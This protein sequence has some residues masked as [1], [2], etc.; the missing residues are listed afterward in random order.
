[1]C[2]IECAWCFE[3]SFSDK[4]RGKRKEIVC[5]FELSLIIMR[6]L[7]GYLSSLTSTTLHVQFAFPVKWWSIKTHSHGINVLSSDSFYKSIHFNFITKWLKLILTIFFIVHLTKCIKMLKYSCTR[8]LHS[9]G[10][11]FVFHRY[12]IAWCF[13]TFSKM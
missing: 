9:F 12:Q 2:L 7:V 5:Y 13:F 10:M 4:A 3:I 8:D 11:L 1:M 6:C